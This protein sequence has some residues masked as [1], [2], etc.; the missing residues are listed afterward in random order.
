MQPALA[1]FQPSQNVDLDLQ[2]FDEWIKKVVTSHNLTP[3]KQAIV[4][5]R[6]HCLRNFGLRE[7]AAGSCCS[8]AQR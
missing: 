2:I 5:Q 1:R 7:N 8:S 6:R 3:Q 4:A